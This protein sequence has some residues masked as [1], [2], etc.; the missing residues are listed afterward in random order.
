MI[1]YQTPPPKIQLQK[2][3]FFGLKEPKRV[4][5]IKKTVKN[6]LE[7]ISFNILDLFIYVYF[8]PFLQSHS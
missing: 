6:T 8:C 3:G 7:N 5:A 2:P 4:K 1:R